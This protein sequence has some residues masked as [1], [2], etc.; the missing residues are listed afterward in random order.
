M[1]EAPRVDRVEGDAV[2][3]MR[4]QQNQR[5]ALGARFAALMGLFLLPLTVSANDIL[6]TNIGVVATD[7]G[8]VPGTRPGAAR[9]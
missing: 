2:V 3:T 5:R 8:V 4:S 7:S 1:L 9:Y 6:G